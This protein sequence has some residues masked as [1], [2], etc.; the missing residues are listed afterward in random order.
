MDFYADISSKIFRK[1]EFFPLFQS[2]KSNILSMLFLTFK[3]K[4][5]PLRSHLLK[6]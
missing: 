5:N 1:Q 6:N 2:P 3:L 4:L